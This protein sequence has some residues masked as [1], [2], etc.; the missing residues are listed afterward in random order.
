MHNAQFTNFFLTFFCHVFL[1][2]NRILYNASSFQITTCVTV[3]LPVAFA[4][5]VCGAGGRRGSD[6][7]LLE[8]C[9]AEEGRELLLAKPG[10]AGFSRWDGRKGRWMDGK[11]GGLQFFFL[12]PPL[13]CSPV[14]GLAPSPTPRPL[15]SCFTRRS[16]GHCAHT[17]TDTQENALLLRAAW[18][19]FF[20]LLKLWVC[21]H[22]TPAQRS[23]VSRAK[24][25]TT[26]GI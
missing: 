20:F 17:H 8:T 12:S 14:D 4:A 10:W 6:M 16:C 2:Y 1:F 5:L 19:F 25:K 22:T 7:D 21:T 13:I 9:R 15:C 11:R 24:E 18:C 3:R 26:G 23:A